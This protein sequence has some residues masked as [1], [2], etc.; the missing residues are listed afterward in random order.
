MPCPSCGE[1]LHPAPLERV[2]VNACERCRAVLV[3]QRQLIALL[4]HATSN[5]RDAIDPDAGIA[6]VAADARALACPRCGAAFERVGYLGTEAAHYHEC[7]ACAL[8]WIAAD[9]LATMIGLFARTE[10]REA[11]LEG[12]L[13]RA[14]RDGQA[15]SDAN[16]LADATW[17]LFAVG[18][19]LGRGF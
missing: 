15:V 1:P 17:R 13:A 16:Q 11:D 9:D 4:E 19:S 10:R 7:S 18:A 6:P 8:L 3:E 2:E 14:A 5:L 12:E